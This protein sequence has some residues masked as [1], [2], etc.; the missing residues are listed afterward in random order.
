MLPRTTCPR[1]RRSI[2]VNRNGAMRSHFC[3][4]YRVCEND[5]CP[6]CAIQESASSPETP[7]AFCRAAEQS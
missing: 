1:C 4:H 5:D 6:E 2:A 7:P 3:P